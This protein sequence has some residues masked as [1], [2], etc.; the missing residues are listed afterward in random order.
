[1]F[2]ITTDQFNLIVDYQIMNDQ[3]DRDIVIALADRLLA[4][5]KSNHGVLT[6]V[7]GGKKTSSYYNWKCPSNNAQIRETEQTGGRGRTQQVF[8]IIKK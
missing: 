5:I 1:M 4:I 2:S 7:T 3:H 8:Q 6:K